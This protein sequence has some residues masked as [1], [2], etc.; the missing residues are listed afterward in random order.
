VKS[1]ALQATHVDDDT[2]NSE[3]S[4]DKWGNIRMNVDL[5]LKLDLKG[6]AT[7]E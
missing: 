7:Y 5:A 3:V 6:A 2:P 4:A 1:R